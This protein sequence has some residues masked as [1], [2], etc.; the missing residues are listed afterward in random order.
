MCEHL[1]PHSSGETF[2]PN[3]L[4]AITISAIQS[5]NVCDTPVC[6]LVHQL[7]YHMSV[8]EGARV[9]GVNS[10][11]RYVVHWIVSNLVCQPQRLEYNEE[12]VS[13]FQAVSKESSRFVNLQSK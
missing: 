11:P 8:H 1:H 2:C 10:S 3:D 4:C 5:N 9:N 7:M 12:C 6:K 13:A